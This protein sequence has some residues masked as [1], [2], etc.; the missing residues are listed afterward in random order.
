[1]V[2]SAIM[3]AMGLV[4]P[5][6]FH[7]VGLGGKFL[8]M[9]LPLAAERIPGAASRAMATGALVPLVSAV[10]TGM[11][12]L[13]PPVAF[14]MSLECAVLGGTAAAIYRGRP[15]RLWYA[16]IS[17]IVLGS[18]NERSRVEG[19]R[20]HDVGA[21]IEV[22]VVHRSDDVGTCEYEQIVVALEVARMVLESSAAKVGLRQSLSLDYRAHRTIDYE[23][24][25][26]E[27]L[28]QKGIGIAHAIPT[29]IQ[30]C[31]GHLHATGG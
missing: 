31:F 8:P 27:E 22:R 20:L 18:L 26:R 17:A 25:L 5:I 16:L 30:P 9:L 12:P 2:I 1:M 11:P 4:L 6:A 15:S 28:S 14:S 13:F 3:A 29:M 21:R 7:A 10:T 19:V 24:S 23:N